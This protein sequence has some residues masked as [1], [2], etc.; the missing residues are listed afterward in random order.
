MTQDPI[1]YNDKATCLEAQSALGQMDE[2][3]VCIPAGNYQST[4]YTLDSFFDFVI[5]LQNMPPKEVDIK[6]E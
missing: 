3:A 6:E 4:Q 5:K 2:Q 1:V